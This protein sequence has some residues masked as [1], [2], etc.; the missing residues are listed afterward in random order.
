M[1]YIIVKVRRIR[2]QEQSPQ[3]KPINNPIMI[4]RQKVTEYHSK[5]KKLIRDL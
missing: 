4:L 5:A 1:R 2:Q 3:R